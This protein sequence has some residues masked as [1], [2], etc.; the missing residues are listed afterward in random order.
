MTSSTKV[1]VGLIGLNAPSTGAPTGTNWAASAHLPYLQSSKKYELVALQNSSV[2]R[3]KAAIEAYGLNEER[4][5]AY[6]TSEGR[7]SFLPLSSGS[8]DH[9]P[10]LLVL[11][12]NPSSRLMTH[13]IHFPRISMV[14]LRAVVIS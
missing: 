12:T 9:G 7:I 14:Q 1:R 11:S 6:G 8:S 3:A 10:L 2:E 5:K 4:V 13:S